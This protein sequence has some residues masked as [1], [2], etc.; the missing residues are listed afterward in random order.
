MSAPASPIAGL[1]RDMEDRIGDA[2]DGLAALEQ[3]GR[4]DDW[5][6]GPGRVERLRSAI[7]WTV[8]RLRADLSAAL[9]VAMERR[10]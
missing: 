5:T 1:S 10:G 7:E 2:L 6:A 9:L 4:S 8:G 3:F